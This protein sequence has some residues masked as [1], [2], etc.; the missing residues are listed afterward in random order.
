V[1]ERD[2]PRGRARAAGCAARAA[3]G[4]VSGRSVVRFRRRS[5]RNRSDP[6]RRARQKPAGTRKNRAEPGRTEPRGPRW[7]SRNPVEPKVTAPCR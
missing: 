2:Q 6:A 1:H 4:N 5:S 7:N 3:A